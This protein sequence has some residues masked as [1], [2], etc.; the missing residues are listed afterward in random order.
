MSH[1]DRALEL[2]E[3]GMIRAEDML[4]MALKYMSED[5]VADMLDANEL[6]ARFH[7]DAD[8]DDD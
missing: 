1:R 8:E 3:S 5:D 6:S 7:E 4:T 2:V